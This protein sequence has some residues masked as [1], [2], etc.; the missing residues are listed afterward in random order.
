[1][2]ISDWSSDVCSSDL[3][4][5]ALALEAGGDGLVERR[6]HTLE[7]KAT[8][9]ID[10]IIPLHP[11]LAADHSERSRQP[12]DGAA[13]GLPR[14]RCHRAWPA[15]GAA[16]GGGGTAARWWFWSPALR[17]GERRYNQD[18]RWATPTGPGPT[19]Q[20]NPPT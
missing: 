19:S 17:A 9:R 8:H 4:N 3:H 1:M 13:T 12:Q 11:S 14:R 15:R 18:H 6:S 10:H 20:Q 5:G 16:R 2:R 7:A